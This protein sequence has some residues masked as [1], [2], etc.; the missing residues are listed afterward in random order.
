MG[1]QSIGTPRFYIDT[2]QYLKQIGFDFETHY[3]N[4]YWTDMGDD[5]SGVNVTGH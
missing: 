1:N 3:N 5:N 2:V 4:Y